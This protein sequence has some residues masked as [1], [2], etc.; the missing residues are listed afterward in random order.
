MCA[1]MLIINKLL[2]K[3]ICEKYLKSNVDNFSVDGCPWYIFT[4]IR[5]MNGTKT[6]KK[7]LE[8][9]LRHKNHLTHQTKTLLKH[10]HRGPFKC[11]ITATLSGS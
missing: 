7:K 8:K 1:Y 2:I 4:H 5:K 10:L 3:T 11:K 9:I 6:K